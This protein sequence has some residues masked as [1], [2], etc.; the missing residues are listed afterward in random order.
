MLHQGN[1]SLQQMETITERHN[2]S[3]YKE[4]VT[5]VVP[6]PNWCFYNTIPEPRALEKWDACWWKEEAQ[7][8]CEIE[9][10]GNDRETTQK[11]SSTWLPKQDLNNNN[12]KR[13]IDML[14]WKREMLVTRFPP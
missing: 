8:C 12:N 5:A 11:I 10:P 3:K 2:Q 7:V 13:P 6:S 4:Q 1:V 9:S 14:T